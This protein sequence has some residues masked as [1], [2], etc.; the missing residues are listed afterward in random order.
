ME[1][2]FFQWI[3]LGY[4]LLLSLIYII[5]NVLAFSILKNYSYKLE[6]FPDASFLSVTDMPP[7]TIIAPAFN[8]DLT[9]VEATRSLLTLEYPDYEVLVINDGSTDQTLK[10]MIRAFDMHPTPRMSMADI[11]TAPVRVL[12]RSKNNPNLWLIDKENSGKADSL[13][14]GINYCTS[15]LFCSVDSDSLLER[16]ALTKIV[17]PFMEDTNTIAVGGIVRIVNGCTVS[18]G[19]VTDIRL[20]DNLLVKFQVLEYLRAFL[21]GRMGWAA[22]KA[23][24]IISGAFGLF[25]RETV[26][27]IG[28]YSTRRTRGETVGED[29]ELVVRMSKYCREQKRNYAISY[30]PDAVAWTECPESLKGLKRQRSRWQRGLLEAT[31]RNIGMFFNPRY[32]RLGMVSFPYFF[33]LEGLGPIIELISY[34]YFVV[35]LLDI[36]SA[37]FTFITAYLMVAFVLGIVLSIIAL[38]LEEISFRRYPG[39][40]DLFQLFLLSVIESFGYRQLNAWWRIHGLYTFVM[41]RDGWGNMD[42]KGFRK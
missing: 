40:M 9:C 11:T 34:I 39:L 8:E 28:G 1:V 33:I 2:T 30:I 29:I 19:Q 16:S 32:G 24:I 36:S 13:N 10:R 37:S 5:S 12:Y 23:T 27:Q 25:Q 7:V 14:V 38:C 21:V 26:V 42:R 41:R 17:K 35:L 22:I 6:A 15:S 31:T 18:D 20:S 4:F 3:I